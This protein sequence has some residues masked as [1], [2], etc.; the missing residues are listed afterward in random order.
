LKIQEYD[1]AMNDCQRAIAINEKFAKAYNRM[2]KCYIAIGEL[3]QASIAL[4][5][6]MELEPGNDVNKKDQ[7]HLDSLKI[8]EALVNKALREELYDKAVTNLS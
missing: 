8:T 1:Q 7:K 4:A 2:S 6:S 5:K 3:A